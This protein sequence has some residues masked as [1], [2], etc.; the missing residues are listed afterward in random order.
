[1]FL[2]HQV[3]HDDP[4]LRR[5]YAQFGRNL[6]DILDLA[7][8]HGTPVVISTVVSNLKDCAPFAS[9]HGTSV[10]AEQLRQWQTLYQRGCDAQ[11]G[12]QFEDAIQAFEQASQIDPEFAELQFRLGEC[13]LQL[14]DANRARERYRLARDLDTLRFRASSEINKIITAEAQQRQNRVVRFVDACEPFAQLSPHGIPGEESLCEHVHFDFAGN[15]LLAKLIAEQ[16][17]EALNLPRGESPRDGWPSEQQCADRLGWTPYHQ[18]LF[19]QELKTRLQ[20]PPFNQQLH[21]EARDAELEARI[22]R[23]ASTLSPDTA[24]AAI[25]EYQDLL[26]Q[27]SDDWVLQK[28]FGALLEFTGDVDAATQ[29]WLEITKRLPHHAEAFFKAGSLLNQAKKWHEAEQQLRQALTLRP[30]YARALNSLGIALS[31]QNRFD[32]S[33]AEFAKAVELQP[34]Y[35]E[36]YTNWG[37]VL[38]AHGDANGAAAKY[39]A[40]LE[41]DPDYLKAHAELG[42]YYVGKQQYDAAEPHYRAVV[43]L[44]PKDAAAHINLGLL[45]LKQQRPA[46]AVAEFEQAIALD[47]AN[48]LAQ[49]AL[50]EARRLAAP[51]AQRTDKQR[52]EALFTAQIMVIQ[53]RS[54]SE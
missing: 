41:V 18:L 15:Y 34:D 36:A 52:C 2:D 28:Q 8:D 20:S 5:V 35:A 26:A 12:G 46:E 14:G 27:Y 23:L 37:L 32:E 9:L 31:H 22:T 11:A 16:L 49:Q 6:G 3:R 17:I 33:C 7:I 38:A 21:H 45:C 29:Q 44:K 50:A 10:T 51:Y 30:E 24:R 25:H 47:P 54:A 40:A 42:S 19:A 4:A 43:R 48:R 53:A 1:M 39:R 13:W